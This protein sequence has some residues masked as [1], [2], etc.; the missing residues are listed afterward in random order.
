MNQQIRSVKCVKKQ[1]RIHTVYVPWR[2]GKA[3]AVEFHN[4]S[5]LL[6]ALMAA[7]TQLCLFF[8]NG[9]H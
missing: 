7:G 2:Q 4:V 1:V 5:D 6:V 3:E 8:T 9:F